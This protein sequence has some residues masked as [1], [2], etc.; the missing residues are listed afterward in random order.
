MIGAENIIIYQADKFSWTVL[1]ALWKDTVY[2]W[3]LFYS[4]FC[5]ISSLIYQLSSNY[6]R[7]VTNIILSFITKLKVFDHHQDQSYHNIFRWF[8]MRLHRCDI[9]IF[10][11]AWKQRSI[12]C[13]PD[14]VGSYNK[15]VRVLMIFLLFNYTT[16]N[17]FPDHFHNFIIIVIVP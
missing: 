2:I 14:V 11:R 7:L 13:S 4:W 8:W 10:A 9:L 12:S 5:L 3:F 17:C 1:R 15:E 16:E 6:C